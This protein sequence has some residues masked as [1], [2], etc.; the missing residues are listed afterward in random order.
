[1]KKNK[2]AG[3]RHHL[4]ASIQQSIFCY[5]HIGSETKSFHRLDKMWRAKTAVVLLKVMNF[6]WVSAPV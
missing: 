2:C 6:Q 4:F 3:V 1:M 5:D